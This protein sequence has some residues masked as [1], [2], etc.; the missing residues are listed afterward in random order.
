MSSVNEEKVAE[1]CELLP[2]EPLEKTFW[3]PH[4]PQERAIGR[5][6]EPPANLARIRDEIYCAL[7]Q[8]DVM[9]DFPAA[10]IPSPTFN[11]SVHLAMINFVARRDRIE[12]ELPNM[13]QNQAVDGSPQ[14]PSRSYENDYQRCSA[15]VNDCNRALF[16]TYAQYLD[17]VLKTLRRAG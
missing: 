9:P 2:A 11:P 17:R 5:P 15:R 16:T 6:T 1:K 7:F 3:A 13:S 4:T 14:E 10:K 12:A 8:H